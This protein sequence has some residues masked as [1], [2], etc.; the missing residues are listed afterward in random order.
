MSLP[1][2][3]I[4]WHLLKN[5]ISI[6]FT[7]TGQQRQQDPGM[8]AQRQPGYRVESGLYHPY[9]HRAVPDHVWGCEGDRLSWGHCSGWR[10]CCQ[11]HMWSSRC[12]FIKLFCCKCLNS[13]CWHESTFLCLGNGIRG[14]LIFFPSVCLWLCHFLAKKKPTFNLGHNFRTV[15]DRDYI[16][17]PPFEKGGAYCFAHVGR[18]V[19]M[20][21]GMSVGRSVGMSVAP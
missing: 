14:H 2:W 19:G 6:V 1:K 3:Q 10:Q 15:R 4:Y 17:M 5:N 21:V 13:E 11:W 12:S 16:F 20:S 8:D 18:Y 9:Q 7:T